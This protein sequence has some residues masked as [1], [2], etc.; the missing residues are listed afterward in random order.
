MSNSNAGRSDIEGDSVNLA[1]GLEPLAEP[2]EVLIDNDLRY[3]PEINQDCFDSV[4]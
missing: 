4:G 1:A 2:G 3:S